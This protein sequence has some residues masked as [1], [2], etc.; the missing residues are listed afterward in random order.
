MWKLSVPSGRSARRSMRPNTS[1]ASPRSRSFSRLTRASSNALRSKRACMVP[2]RSASWMSRSRHADVLVDSRHSY[3]KSTYACSDSSSGCCWVIRPW[4][5]R[6]VE[7]GGSPSY[8]ALSPERSRPS[9]SPVASSRAWVMSPMR[10]E[11]SWSRRAGRRRRRRRCGSC[12]RPGA[13]CPSTGRVR[14]DGV[15]PRRD[16]ATGPRGRDHAAA[17]A[18]LRRRR[19]RPVLRHR[20][21]G[22]RGRIRHRRR[23]GDRARSP[24]RR[25]AAAPTSIVSGH[26][27]PDDI[28]YVTETVGDRRRRARRRD[29][30]A[31]VRRR[32]VHGR[33]LP[34]R[35]SPEP[36]LR[37]HQGADAQRRGAV[38][39][40]ARTAWRRWRSR[41]STSSSTPGPGHSSCSTRGPARCRPPTTT[42]SCSPTRAACSAELAER[43]PGVPGIHFGIG[44]DHLL[45][46]MVAA[47]PR[48]D[49]PR[50]AHVDLRRPQAARRPHRRPGQPRP[51]ARPRRGRARRSPGTATCSPTTPV[52]P[53]TCSTSATASTRAPTPSVLAAVVDLVHAETA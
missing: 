15:D 32:A 50:L 49:R 6:W 29:S 5:G 22:P 45:E 23:A 11:S 44:C 24:S 19:R 42:A 17:G 41:S 47:G 35:G 10:T 30:G 39:R 25:S 52:V 46:S 36:H 38:A 8:L 37:A 14:G 13:A 51:G 40:R 1:A 31:G 43:H 16:Q 33:Q 26:S 18:P 12:A 21:A 7:I 20:R 3:A 28:G 27:I 2:P 4:S 53:A 9:P 34:D 48:D